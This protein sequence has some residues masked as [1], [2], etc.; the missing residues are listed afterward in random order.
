MEL[1]MKE[2]ER[3]ALVEVLGEMLRNLREEVYK[4][5]DFNYREELKQREVLVKILLRRLGKA[6]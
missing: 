6:A 1:A 4:T 2:E 5:E 3:Q